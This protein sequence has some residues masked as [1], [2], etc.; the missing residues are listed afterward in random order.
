MKVWGAPGRSCSL[1]TGLAAVDARMRVWTT[2]PL[3]KRLLASVD[4][5]GFKLVG[6]TILQQLFE[7]VGPAVAH[8]DP[9]LVFG[10]YA[11]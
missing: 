5:L 11:Q 7:A 1:L 4:L 6:E 9:A 2:R 10:H 3:A 8:H